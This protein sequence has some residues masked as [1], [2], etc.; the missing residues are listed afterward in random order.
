MMDDQT[1][2]SAL[3]TWAALKEQWRRNPRLQAGFALIIGLVWL[4][5]CLV[6]LDEAELLRVQA[7]ADTEATQQLRPIL[8]QTQWPARADEIQRLL[9]AAR[10]LQWTATSPG[11]A[12][13]KLQDE[14][15]AW[16]A[17]AGLT[18]V[19]LSI[20]PGANADAAQTPAGA[21]VRARLVTDLNRNALMALLA[22]L[23]GAQP[24][25]MVDSIKLRP[26]QNPSRAEVELRVQTRTAPA[27]GAAS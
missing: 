22:Q 17:K 13:A 26:A 12:E 2:S 25:V 23:Q 9:A 27:E 5:G 15:K 4:W 6:V 19:E 10:E 8:S 21:A 24:M 14:L 11:A 3:S 20:L 18:V 1:S 16:T 7:A